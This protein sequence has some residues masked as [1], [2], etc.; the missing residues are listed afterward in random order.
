MNKNNLF[1]KVKRKRSEK[2]MSTLFLIHPLFLYTN[3]IT[4]YHQFLVIDLIAIFSPLQ[5]SNQ[6]LFSLSNFPQNFY[7]KAE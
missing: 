2:Q 1:F 7:V 3:Y 4:L 5:N 6:V